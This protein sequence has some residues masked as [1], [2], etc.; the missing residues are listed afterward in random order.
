MDCSMVHGIIVLQ[1]VLRAS[2][3]ILNNYGG[4]GSGCSHCRQRAARGGK[5]GDGT[6]Y[7]L[8]GGQDHHDDDVESGIN[9]EENSNDN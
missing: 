7:S 4:G 6:T 9:R 3:I 1:E 5:P 2:G 8:L